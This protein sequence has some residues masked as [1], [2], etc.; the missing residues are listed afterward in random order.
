VHSLIFWHNCAICSII[1]PSEIYLILFVEICLTHM[2]IPLIVNVEVIANIPI[3]TSIKFTY[4][5]LS[6]TCDTYAMSLR[7][8]I[9]IYRAKKP[10]YTWKYLFLNCFELKILLHTNVKNMIGRYLTSRISYKRN[11][12]NQIRRVYHA[13]ITKHAANSYLIATWTC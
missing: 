3:I 4:K 5:D 10:I 6:I 2:N 7:L 11:I 9:L 8:I 12:T 1:S 13:I